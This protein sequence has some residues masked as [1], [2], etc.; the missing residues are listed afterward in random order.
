M[1]TEDWGLPHATGRTGTQF[2]VGGFAAA[3]AACTAGRCAAAVSP[4]TVS[5]GA[6]ASAEGAGIQQL[7]QAAAALVHLESVQWGAAQAQRLAWTNCRRVPAAAPAATSHATSSAHHAG[8]LTLY[9]QPPKPS[10]PG[11][12]CLGPVRIEEAV[13]DAVQAGRHRLQSGQGCEA[14]SG[15]HKHES[16]NAAVHSQRCVARAPAIA[17]HRKHAKPRRPARG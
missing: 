14:P 7:L 16:R 13:G 5:R 9:R 10:K 3:V 6:A 12:T 2:A 8:C 11:G 4:S 17:N 1:R 15:G